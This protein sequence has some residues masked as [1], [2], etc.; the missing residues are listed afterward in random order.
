LRD[1]SFLFLFIDGIAVAEDIQHDLVGSQMGLYID[2]SKA[3]KASS[4]F[5]GLIDDIRG[6]DVALTT[7]EIAALLFH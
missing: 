7:E 6:Y 4:F 1:V 2:N 3:M 5:S